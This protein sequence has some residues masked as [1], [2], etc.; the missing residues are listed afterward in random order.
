MCDCKPS[1]PCIFYKVPHFF[2]NSNYLVCEGVR[3]VKMNVCANFQPKILRFICL[4]RALKNCALKIGGKKSKIFHIWETKAA[5]DLQNE[6][7]CLQYTVHFL[8]QIALITVLVLW[9]PPPVQ[10]AVILRKS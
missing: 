7:K 1:H 3:N 9:S 10:A 5:R 4:L 2:R 8:F 6:P